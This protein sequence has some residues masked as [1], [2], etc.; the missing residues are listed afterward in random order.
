MQTRN[1]T[2][3]LEAKDPMP[4]EALLLTNCARVGQVPLPV[5][6]D[7]LWNLCFIIMQTTDIIP[8]ESM[9]LQDSST[10]ES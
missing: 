5:C 9:I 7:K 2:L 4:F 8:P 10:P 6:D 1:R 3:D